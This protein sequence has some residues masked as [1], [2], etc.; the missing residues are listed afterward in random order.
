[1]TLATGSKVG[2][3]EI[4]GPLG[5]GGM[6]EDYRAREVA[7]KILPVQFSSPTGVLGYG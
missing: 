1:M 4:V 6:G 3:Y 5:V 7:I 2:P